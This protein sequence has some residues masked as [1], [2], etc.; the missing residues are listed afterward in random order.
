MSSKTTT[1]VGAAT[2]RMV[3]AEFCVTTPYCLPRATLGQT[4]PEWV[5]RS[6]LSTQPANRIFHAMAYD[7][8]RSVSVLFGGYLYNTTHL[9]TDDTWEWD[10][11]SWLRRTSSGP[12][13]RRQH[14]MAFD[15]FRNVTVL[16]GGLS[17]NFNSRE[18]WEWNG[19]TWTLRGQSGGPSGRSAHTACYDS[20][21]RVMIVFGGISGGLPL[22]DTWEWSGTSWA[23]VP[24]AGPTAR[25]NSAMAFD[26]ARGV[27]VLFGGVGTGPELDDTWE[28]DGTAWTQL[29]QF[30]PSPRK[31][32]MMCYDTARAKTV[33]FGGVRGCCGSRD[34][35][36]WDGVDWHRLP[37]IT[38]LATDAWAATAFVFDESRHTGVLFGEGSTWEYRLPCASPQLESQPVSSQACGDRR[39]VFSF[40]ASTSPDNTFSWRRLV[41]PNTWSALTDGPTAT[42]SLIAGADTPVLTISHASSFDVATYSCATLNP[43]DHVV[44]DSVQLTLCLADTDCSGSITP[45]DLFSFMQQWFSGT[46][47]ADFDDSGI[48]GV[49]DIFAYITAWFVGCD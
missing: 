6:P 46:S 25:S 17:G 18:T 32:H 34:T 43:C 22:S 9:E 41:A 49:D 3:L 23:N 8:A 42:G 12:S 1:L 38:G 33:L 35:W 44:T 30:G 47:Q 21:R 14:S 45:T 19:V 29:P 10:G 36:E 27:A 28:Y 2:L 24:I 31:H 13:P 37:P 48:V 26:S 39:G 4:Y 7:S 11:H 15:S 40:S 16:F 5:Q 20:Q